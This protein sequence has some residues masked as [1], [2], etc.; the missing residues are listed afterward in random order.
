MTGL[1]GLPVDDLGTPVPV[2]GVPA[3]VVSLVPN[4]SEALWWWGRASTLVGVTQWCVSPD[5]GFPDAVRVRGTKNPDLAAIV[6]LA[7]DLVVANL[8]ENRELDVRRLREAGL[9]VHVTAPVDGS[10]AADSLARLGAVVGAAAPALATADAIRTA[11]RHH[12]PAEGVWRPR[13]AV[14]VWRDPWVT[15]GS[16]TVVGGL[17]RSVG[18]ELVPDA[19]RY[20]TVLPG[21][22][23]GTD[24]VLLPDEPWAFGEAD[25]ELLLAR[26]PGRAV[27][28]VDGQDLTW[29]G[30]RTPGVVRD[31]A[32]LRDHLVRRA[33]RRQR[34]NGGASR[35]QP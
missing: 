22:L 4:L 2:V 16:G 31:L 17:L 34:R 28:L 24:L 6:A 8:E 15:V 29:W 13:V 33:A 21:D 26:V 19:P 14:P 10:S 3:R 18:F 35:S 1:V 30:P 27:R 5:D 25:R 20:P 12:A 7:P 9:A 11:L 23:D 32:A